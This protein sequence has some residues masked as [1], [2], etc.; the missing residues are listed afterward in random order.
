MIFYKIKV[1]LELGIFLT[2]FFCFQIFLKINF[3]YSVLFLIILHIYPIIFWNNIHKWCEKNW[4]QIEYAFKQQFFKTIFKNYSMIFSKIKVCLE[5]GIFL[6]CFLCFQIFLKINFI[7]SVLFLI[8]LH[9]YPIIFWNNI[10]KWCEKNWQQIEYA[11]KKQY[12]FFTHI[13]W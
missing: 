4:Q 2:C 1:Y 11:F 10:H 7:F 9:I 6:T 13:V 12:V 5:L 3:I 8:I